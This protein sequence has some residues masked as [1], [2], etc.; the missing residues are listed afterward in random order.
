MGGRGKA[1]AMKQAFGVG[2]VG[3][4]LSSFE[5]LAERWDWGM[6]RRPSPREG[7]GAARWFFMPRVCSRKKP[8]RGQARRTRRS[9]QK[10]VNKPRMRRV[11]DTHARVKSLNP[12]LK[13]PLLR[14]WLTDL[15]GPDTPPTQGEAAFVTSWPGTECGRRAEGARNARLTWTVSGPAETGCDFGVFAG[16]RNSSQQDGLVQSGSTGW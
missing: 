10:S 8:V 9:T 11:F 14:C 3:K 1:Q 12:S 4:G 5:D 6:A 13:T 2:T 16:A 15:C 7:W